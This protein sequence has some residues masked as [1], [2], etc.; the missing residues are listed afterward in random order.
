M[1]E[2]RGWDYTGID[3]EPGENVDL[4]VSPYDYPFDSGL[5]DLI[6]SGQAIEH[7]RY[8]WKWIE[9]IYRLVRINGHVIILGPSE[10]KIHFK[11]D[12]WRILPDGM[13]ALLEWAGFREIQTDRSCSKWRCVAGWGRK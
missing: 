9:E 11:V 7:V 8:I 13:V 2:S 12:C 3:I 1:I 4:V 6:I 10:G 5:F